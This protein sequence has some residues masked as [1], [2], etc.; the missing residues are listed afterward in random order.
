MTTTTT[1]NQQD[2]WNIVDALKPSDKAKITKGD[3]KLRHEMAERNRPFQQ[4]VREKMD[5]YAPNRDAIIAKAKADYDEAVQ[6]AEDKYRTIREAAQAEF[7]AQTKAVIEISNVEWKKN[8]DLYHTA[9]KALVSEISG[10]E[11]G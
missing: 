10:K 8:Y 5:M 7:N 9:W 3:N 6:I 2:V 4:V 1:Y 11:I